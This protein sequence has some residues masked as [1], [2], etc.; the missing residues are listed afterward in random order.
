MDMAAITFVPARVAQRVELIGAMCAL[1][2]GGM[3]IMIV[4]APAGCIV[5]TTSHRNSTPWIR[6]LMTPDAV[7]PFVPIVGRI[8]HAQVVMGAA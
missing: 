8:V 6:T 3:K 1:A 2:T 5:G 4:L 7:V